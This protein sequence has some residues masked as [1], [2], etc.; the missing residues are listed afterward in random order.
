MVSGRAIRGALAS[1]V[2]N[3]VAKGVYAL[4]AAPSA[5]TAARSQGG[6]V[7]HL[8]AAEHWGFGVITPPALPHVTLRPGRVRR[9]AGLPCVLHWADVPALDDVTTPLRT[10]LDCL[11]ILPPAE[12]LAIADSA[13]RL[14]SVDHDEL[15]AAAA[16][17]RGP[18]RLRIQRVVA[19]ADRRSESVLESVLR[20]LLIDRGIEGFVPQFVVR[21]AEFSARLDLGN[22]GLLL[23]LE[24]DG[25]EFHGSRR[26][27]VN[28]CRRQANL[29]IR[30]WRVLRFS[31]EDIMYDPDWV[32]ATIERAIGL[33]PLSNRLLRAA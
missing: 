19:S 13:L 4:P 3:R 25:F 20:A 11:R 15:L 22:P 14:G 2:I 31:W 7:S 18:H 9:Q 30:G 27:L 32:I 29:T 23:D 5:L 6:V 28:D 16:Q 17:L 1:G 21:D 10:V 8:S 33:P 24:A 26:A 12:G